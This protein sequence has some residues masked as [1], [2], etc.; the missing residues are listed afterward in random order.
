MTCVGLMNHIPHISEL[1]IHN[2]YII[3][4]LKEALLE[5]DI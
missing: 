3:R 2:I 1:Y 5:G 4:Y